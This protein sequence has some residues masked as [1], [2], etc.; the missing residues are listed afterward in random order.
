MTFSLTYNSLI[1]SIQDYTEERNPNFVAAIPQFINTAEIKIARDVKNIEARK[2]VLANFT[3]WQ[4]LYQKP[5]RWRQT[6]SMNFSTGQSYTPLLPR[7]YEFCRE[8][9]PDLTQTGTPKYYADADL[10][11]FLIVPTPPSASNWQIAY[12]ETP[13]HLSDSNQTNWI[14]ENAPDLL[15]YGA[16]VE[17]APYLKND[18]RLAVWQQMYANALQS[19][20]TEA[21]N[22][23]DDATVKRNV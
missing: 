19:R 20:Q 11:Y 12:Y 13:E 7:S 16:L 5:A 17:T 10:N 23:K 18:N 2:T 14:T 22:R 21:E 15:L 8:Y 6:I 9:W 3:P 1:D 4:A